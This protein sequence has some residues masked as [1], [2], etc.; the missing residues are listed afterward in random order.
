[1]ELEQ[2]GWMQQTGISKPP[3]DNRKDAGRDPNTEMG[4]SAWQPVGGHTAPM[5]GKLASH[6][7]CH[8]VGD[9][10]SGEC[11]PENLYIGT[12]H[13][14]TEQLA[15]ETALHK[16]RFAY[17]KRGWGIEIR[18]SAMVKVAIHQGTSYLTAESVRYEIW[19][20][21]TGKPRIP[22]HEQLMDAQRGIIPTWEFKA[23]EF[24]VNS[25]LEQAH[26]TVDEVE[27][28]KPAPFNWT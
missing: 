6:E 17:E 9:A 22:V 19:L 24:Y 28:Y 13:V 10:D 2:P 23:L 12:N 5:K 21:K 25:R 14:N 7:W 4:V 11:A 3:P 15:M 20:V 26:K 18:A 16:H 8:L 1:M 27:A